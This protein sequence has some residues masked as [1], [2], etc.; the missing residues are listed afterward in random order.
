M[1]CGIHFAWPGIIP[2]L[3]DLCDGNALTKCWK[4]KIG[5]WKGYRCWEL[6]SESAG[7]MRN[8]ADEV[9]YWRDG[10]EEPVKVYTSSQLDEEQEALAEDDLDSDFEAEL[11][12]VVSEAQGAELSAADADACYS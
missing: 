3:S 2:A 6:K 11:L 5:D 8:I 4:G 1:R 7:G 10:T 12:G 9:R